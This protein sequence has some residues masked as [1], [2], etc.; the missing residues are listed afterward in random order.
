MTW[1][2]WHAKPGLPKRQAMQ[3]AYRQTHIL[4]G[5]INKTRNGSEVKVW[6]LGDCWWGRHCNDHRLQ[7]GWL[8]NLR[9]DPKNE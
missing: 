1:E 7:L 6:I 8:D 9:H 4:R 3:G 5:V 2:P